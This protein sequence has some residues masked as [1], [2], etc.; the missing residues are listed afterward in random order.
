MPHKFNAE[1]RYKFAAA[2]YRGTNWRDYNEALRRRGD[3]TVWFDES[4]AGS[5]RAPQSVGQLCF[6]FEGARAFGCRLIQNSIN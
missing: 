4:A 1:R 3:V 6:R 5:W 2:R